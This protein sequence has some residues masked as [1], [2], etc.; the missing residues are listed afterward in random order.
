MTTPDERPAP[1]PFPRTFAP[2]EVLAGRYEV[3]R[4]V[5]R[6]GMG[7][8]YEAL[9][10]ELGDPVALKVLHP[11]LARDDRAVER[12][13]REIRLA[14][15]VAHPNVCRVF[16][17]EFH[18]DEAGG[19]RTAFLTMEFLP[20]ETLEELLRSRRR[21]EPS[22]A[23][24]I[25]RQVAGA[26]SA[27]HESGVVHRDLKP[28]NVLLVPEA[29]G[30]KRAVVTDF[31][32]AAVRAEVEHGGPALTRSGHVV[33]TASYMA[34]EQAQG[35]AA[36]AR[37][38]VYALGVV[39]FEML[40]GRRPHEGDSAV[41]LLMKRVSDPP[42]SPR[43][44]L[45]DVDPVW[46]RVILRCLERQP[47]ARFGEVSD[48]VAALEGREGSLPTEAFPSIPPPAA[49]TAPV[50]R[51]GVS[52]RRRRVA[53][54]AAGLALVAL[55][56]GA[57]ALWV[58]RG[59]ARTPAA[60]PLQ[61]VQ[62]TTSAG[63]DLQP[64]FSPDGQSIAY[65][66][67]RTG[68]FELYVRSLAAGGREIALTSDGA[69]NF[70]P[71]F[72]PDGQWVAYHS[73][74]R[75]GIHVVPALGGAPRLLSEFGSH[76]AF[77]PDGT[78]VAFQSDAFVDLAPSAMNALPPSTIW[79][80]PFAGGAARPVTAAGRPAGGHGAPAFSPD[81]SRIAFISADTRNAEIWM[82][83]AGGGEPIPVV[84]D[85]PT[86]RDPVFA[87]D[88][89]SILFC[90]SP[91][92]EN[93]GILEVPINAS[94][95]SAGRPAR[96]TSLGLSRIRNVAVSR[97]G[98]RLS[99]S[100]VT[101]RSNLWWV[102][103]DGRGE[104]AGPARAL[105][106]ETGRTARP[107]FSPDGS[108][109]AFSRFRAGSNEDVW[110]VSADGSGATQVTTDPAVDSR[111]DWFPDG[112]RLAFF[113]NRGGK[114]A[115]YALSL[116][117]GREELLLETGKDIDAPRLSPDG[118]RIA[119]N[120][121]Q[122]GPLNVWLADLPTGQRRKLTD[123]PELVG[124]PCWSP[125]GTALA[126]QQ[127]RGEDTRL[128]IVDAATGRLTTVVSTKGQ[129]WPHS[130]S[131]DGARIAFAGERDGRWNVFTVPRAGGPETAATTFEKLTTY[132]RYPSWSP[133][134][135]RIVFEFAETSGNVWVVERVASP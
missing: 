116:A 112:K 120:S 79:V 86:A 3:L 134:G 24:P 124:W 85:Q 90:G 16:D 34:P 57:V 123:D 62:V 4:H 29:G 32:L 131:P 27:A 108:R 35:L 63:L 98:R 106:A 37:A 111:P 77:S 56:A 132:V 87:P 13:K 65:A 71:A 72:S 76:P 15:R 7:E 58:R 80:V 55:L 39:M 74:G 104:P 101:I 110:T 73:R 99:Y 121:R 100:A 50:P 68:T 10:R 109:I 18:D 84:T 49:A 53:A 88:G 91:D 28:A 51:D 2:G 66:S 46:E 117:T 81:G 103:M 59:P 128:A 119:Y 30:R 42:P 38:D 135:D 17:L 5:A 20:G 126:V 94:G 52:A 107:V 40:T 64:A 78:Q 97:D 113:S 92:R 22:E 70:Q 83:P 125:D 105:T 96:L 45:P 54:G 8:V 21:L 14:R 93:S 114:G 89:R 102:P 11:D 9:D 43:A 127:R 115:L 118:T 6:G 122:G 19:G 33:G 25:V 12:F 130:F 31:G 48:V 60:S 75:G 95:R 26:L 61:G 82:A 44:Y 47:A 129:S 133:K 36:T 69:Q 1:A 67:D 23:L 41:T